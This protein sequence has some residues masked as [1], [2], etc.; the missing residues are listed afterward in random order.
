MS[1]ARRLPTSGSE[2]TSQQRASSGMGRLGRQALCP[3][4]LCSH[5]TLYDDLAER[6]FPRRGFFATRQVGPANYLC[7]GTGIV[8]SFHLDSGRI[9]SPV[10]PLSRGVRPAPGAYRGPGVSFGVR[11]RT[12]L[13][14]IRT[15]DI[16][17]LTPRIIA[18]LCS[19]RY[20]PLPA[21]ASHHLSDLVLLL[22]SS[23]GSCQIH[24]NR[25]RRR[26]V[27][28]ILAVGV[29]GQLTVAMWVW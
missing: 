24:V 1:C 12:P 17:R 14:D 26:Q 18:P 20:L 21:K 7:E 29:S 13:V 8:E 23:P 10:G 27:L 28:S 5:W 22:A 11:V 19:T 25:R 2:L 6:C 15:A 16:R 4:P 3:G 9:S